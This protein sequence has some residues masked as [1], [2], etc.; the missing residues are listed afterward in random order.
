MADTPEQ[1]YV[2]LRSE[3]VQEI[4][5]TPPHW[6]VRWGTAIVLMGFVMM[7]VAAWFIRYPDVV[8]A[9]VFITTADPPVNV[10]AR[11]TGRI[12]TLLVTDKA[13]VRENDLLAVLK[14]AA[15]Y[16]HVF[17]MDAAVNAWQNGGLDSLRS[18]TPPRNFLLGDIQADYED[19]VEQLENFQFG[20]ENKNAALNSNIGSINQQINQLEQSIVFEEKGLKRINDQLKTAEE[21]YEKQKSLYEEGLISQSDFAKERTELAN[22][23]RQRD[24]YE[25]NIL[26]K[27]NEII[28]LKK[29]IT[30][31]TFNQQEVASNTS[32]RLL[33]SL[34]T[35][36]NSID[37][38][39]Q[40]YLI[41]APITGQV[42]FNDDVKKRFFEES[43]VVFTVVPPQNDRIV[44]RIYLPAASSSKIKLKQRV[45]LKL[46]NYPYHEFGTLKSQ[47]IDKSLV[48]KGDQFT[49]TVSVPV[50]KNTTKLETTYGRQIDFDPQLQG[51]AEIILE[52]KG[53]IA[54]LTD[55]IFAAR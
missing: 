7:I 47:V 17:A 44:G 1:N 14:S 55:Q 8:E 39:K 46:D 40:N 50:N 36:R 3:D 35:L 32:N 37:K 29:N 31:A 27:R 45:I 22:L 16:K 11:V 34:S 52:D 42:S 5:G 10:V 25:D 38:W 19:F 4:L 15:N 18:L 49:I 54:R 30:D 51:T 28:G 33:G 20:K 23:E 26:R 12:D 6:L 9:R 41:T 21:L 24:Q 2:E 43:E 48:P 53:L 13:D